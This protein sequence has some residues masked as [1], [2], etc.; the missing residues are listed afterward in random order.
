MRNIRIEVASCPVPSV[1]TFTPF[2]AEDKAKIH[3]APNRS[4]P[5][6]TEMPVT[7]Q[8]V[9]PKGAVLDLWSKGIDKASAEE[10]D[11]WRE[12]DAI[13]RVGDLVDVPAAVTSS[14]IDE[15]DAEISRRQAGLEKYTRGE[16]SVEDQREAVELARRTA[17][18]R[19][20]AAEADPYFL[21]DLDEEETLRDNFD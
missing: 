9:L 11:A 4:V 1:D 10:A 12:Y 13:A 8:S 6:G 5:F 15:I 18:L 19:D 16:V 21:Q 3:T 14:V 7:V 2:A 20:G 17:A